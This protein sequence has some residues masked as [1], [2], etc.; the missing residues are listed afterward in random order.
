MEGT[1]IGAF[2]LK[3]LNKKD[4]LVEN[5]LDYHRLERFRVLQT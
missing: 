1:I 3:S 2:G 4:I 5:M